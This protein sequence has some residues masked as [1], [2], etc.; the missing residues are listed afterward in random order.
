MV[1]SDT[2]TSIAAL[3]AAASLKE[4]GD[5]DDKQPTATIG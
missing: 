3:A 4:K 5:V 1:S 2:T